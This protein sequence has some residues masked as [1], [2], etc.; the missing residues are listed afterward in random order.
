MN[1]LPLNNTLILSFSHHF[2]E[3]S[4]NYIL[5][6]NFFEKKFIAHSRGFSSLSTQINYLFNVFENSATTHKVH[7]STFTSFFFKN[8]KIEIFEINEASCLFLET[9]TIFL[10]MRR[11]FFNPL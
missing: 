1:F 9:F 8:N 5:E 11:V 6:L 4:L 3:S 7:F 10:A 2:T